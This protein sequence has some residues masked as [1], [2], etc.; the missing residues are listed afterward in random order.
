MKTL[1]TFI[2][3]L[4]VGSNLIKRQ[5]HRQEDDLISLHLFFRNESRLE[6]ATFKEIISTSV[7]MN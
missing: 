3:K 6:Y 4:P 7:W 1:L 2:K 5:A